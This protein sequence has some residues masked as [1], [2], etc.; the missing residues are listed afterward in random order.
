M[1]KSRQKKEFLL[2][3]LFEVK[4]QLKNN[5]FFDADELI[6]DDVFFSFFRWEAPGKSFYYYFPTFAEI[7]TLL[8]CK[9]IVHVKEHILK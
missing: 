9:K 7:M 1:K 2:S 6:A 8:G 4:Q 5:T 3:F